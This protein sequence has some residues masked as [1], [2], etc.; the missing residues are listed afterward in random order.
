MGG[1]I[2]WL[3]TSSALKKQFEFERNSKKID[4]LRKILKALI[5]V[6]REIIHNTLE[7]DAILNIMENE[8]MEFINFAINNQNINLANVNWLEFNHELV[9]FDLKLKINKIE[10]Y[11]HNISLEITNN[12]TNESRVEK[13]KKNGLESKNILD[14][15]IEFIKEKIEKV[16]L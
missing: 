9:N 1:G 11:Y 10:T 6:R 4:R 14:K 8:D 5:V 15:N 16:K 7:A 12:Y 3:T 13:I 2:T